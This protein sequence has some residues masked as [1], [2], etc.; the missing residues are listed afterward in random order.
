[1]LIYGHKLRAW[2]RWGLYMGYFR[3]K[4]LTFEGDRGRK[5]ENLLQ[6]GMDGGQGWR[7]RG[8]G[9]AWGAVGADGAG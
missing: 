3:G 6:R 7:R 8:R 5:N 4:Y 1:M 2:Y 9:M